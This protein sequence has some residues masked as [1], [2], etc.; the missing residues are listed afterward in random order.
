[1][2]KAPHTKTLIHTSS[3]HVRTSWKAAILTSKGTSLGMV[4]LAWEHFA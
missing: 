1:M 2:S 4:P 3:H